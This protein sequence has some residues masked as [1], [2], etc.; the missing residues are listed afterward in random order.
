MNLLLLTN[1]YFFFWLL[2]KI[3]VKYSEKLRKLI[4][5]ERK[6]SRTNDDRIRNSSGIIV[7]EIY[8]IPGGPY[9]FELV[10]RFCYNNNNIGGTLVSDII[11]VSNVSIL[12]C[13]AKFLGMTEKM[14]SNNLLHQT[15]IFLERICYWSW[16]DILTCLKNS[17]FES[18]F[19]DSCSDFLQQRLMYA[20]LAKIAENNYNNSSNLDISQS[21]TTTTSSS[22]ASS[23]SSRSWSWWF[24]D[25][26]LLSPKM[27]Q[28][29][30]KTSGC[31]GI[32]NTSLVQ[33]KFLLRYL[34][35]KWKKDKKKGDNKY[36]FMYSGLAD[37]A[38][39]GVIFN[40]NEKRELFSC[41]G[42][43][44]VLRVVSGFGPSKECRTGLEKLIAGML[45]QATLDDLIVLGTRQDGVLYDVNLVV[46]LIRL[47]VHHDRIFSVQKLNKVGR[48]MEKYLREIAPDPNL[49]ISKFLAVA[50]SLPDCT[51]DCFDGIYRAIDIFLEVTLL[52]RLIC[53]QY[54]HRLCCARL[55]N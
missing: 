50:E 30:L 28:T 27:I 40:F 23:S 2:Q 49:K 19:D 26:S 52:F 24:D 7:I 42:L 32:D 47:F 22:S 51:R 41:R 18:D 5:Q 37:T 3:M 33:T 14:C 4:K 29:F 21:T 10:A 46:R 15:D 44:W 25:L 13:C 36:M 6:R 20:V 53:I 8:D 16:N 45:D 39:H 11:T 43:F 54:S 12:H 31:Y 38:I 55:Y 17:E 34:K 48:L 9:G 35:G 1:F